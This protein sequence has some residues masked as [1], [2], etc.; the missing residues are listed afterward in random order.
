MTLVCCVNTV[1]DLCVQLLSVQT[2]A[3][4]EEVLRFYIWVKV[5]ST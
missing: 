1:S 2:E 3:E 4:L 5:N